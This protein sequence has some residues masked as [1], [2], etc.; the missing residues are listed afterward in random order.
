MP[1]EV[2]LAYLAGIIDGEGCICISKC[3]LPGWFNY[4]LKLVISTVDL[5]LIQWV[6]FM[7]PDFKCYEHKGGN[8]KLAKRTSYVLNCQNEKARN[9]LRLV[10]PYL[11]IKKDRAEY[12]INNY[13]KKYEDNPAKRDEVYNRLKM[14]N[15]RIADQFQPTK[16]ESQ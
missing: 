7:F 11:V 10:L 14:F 15:Q 8:N 9:I 4:N 13:P 2:S 1:T 16:G 6:S 12:V 3:K 5:T